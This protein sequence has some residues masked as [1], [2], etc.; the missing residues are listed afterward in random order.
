[1]WSCYHNDH[2]EETIMID[3]FLYTDAQLCWTT[4]LTLFLQLVCPVVTIHDLLLTSILKW[5]SRSSASVVY[6]YPYSGIRVILR[7]LRSGSIVARLHKINQG[8]SWLRHVIEWLVHTPSLLCVQHVSTGWNHHRG[9]IIHI[10]SRLSQ[11]IE[12]MCLSLLIKIETFWMAQIWGWFD[13]SNEIFIA[14]W[15][16]FSLSGLTVDVCCSDF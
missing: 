14:I 6:P 4:A 13:Q 7:S 2:E 11:Q 15:Y 16:R 10:I 8:W 9:L 1:M 3:Y 12:V 5:P